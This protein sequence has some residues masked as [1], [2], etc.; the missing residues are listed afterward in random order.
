MSS[1]HALADVASLIGEPTRA[2]MLLAL[3]DGRSL[4]ATAL[5]REARLSAPATSLHLAKLTQGGLLTVQPEGR[6]RLYRLAGPRVATALEALGVLSTAAPPPRRPPDPLRTARSCY[7]HLAGA[8]GVSFAQTLER[9]QM[10]VPV[11]EAAYALSPSGARWLSQRLGLEPEAVETGRRPF[12][13]RCLDWT[14]RRPHLAGALGAAVLSRMLE[15]RWL[16]R[17]R[18]SRSLRLTVGGEKRL[19][20]LGLEVSR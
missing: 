8:L 5:A 12:A 15:L 19:G 16:A 2:A 7:D 20:E 9:R 18:G 3:L 6:Q 4:P 17:T 14:E 11:G 1:H 13:L 10:L